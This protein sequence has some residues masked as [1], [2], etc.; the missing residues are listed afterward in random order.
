MLLILRS[1]RVLANHRTD[2]LASR[3][4]FSDVFRLPLHGERRNTVLLHTRA[5]RTNHIT[6]E[7]SKRGLQIRHG[8]YLAP[9]RNYEGR[10]TSPRASR[11]A[12]C[13]HGKLRD[14]FSS[15]Q[16][17]HPCNRRS[18]CIRFFRPRTTGLQPRAQPRWQREQRQGSSSNA[19]F[20]GDDGKRVCRE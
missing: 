15:S 19:G 5:F 6:S 2:R 17:G 4:K 13:R 10:Q 1:A 16:S 7:C 3:D 14:S 9:Y 18:R 12:S 11:S 20:S 8:D